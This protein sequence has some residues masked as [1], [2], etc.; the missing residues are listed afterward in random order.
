[1]IRIRK[2]SARDA[3]PAGSRRGGHHGLRM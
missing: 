2:R 3:G 1:L